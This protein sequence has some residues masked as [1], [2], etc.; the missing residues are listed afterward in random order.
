[1][2]TVQDGGGARERGKR[3][4]DDDDDLG[5]GNLSLSKG[6]KSVDGGTSDRASSAAGGGKSSYYSLLGEYLC[7]S[8]MDYLH[9]FV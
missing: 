7:V 8:H 5:F 2:N 9:T 4:E 1:M 3:E 6:T